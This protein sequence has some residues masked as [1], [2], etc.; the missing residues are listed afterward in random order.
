MNSATPG[1][2]RRTA[3]W[4]AVGLVLLA[5]NLRAAISGVAPLLDELQHR[6]N[7]PSTAMGALTTL[8]VLCLGVFAAVAP[9]LARRLGTETTLVGALALIAGGIAMRTLPGPDGLA[10]LLLFAGTV[11]AGAGI[12][13]SNVLM[14][15]V[16]KNVFP[17]RVGLFT[18]LT[19]MLM[20]TG[21][22]LASGLAVPLEERGGWRFSLAVWAFPALL[23]VLVWI[24]LAL[25]ARSAPRSGASSEHGAGRAERTGGSPLR[26]RLAWSVTLFLGMQS[27]VFYVLMSWLPA[28]MR[29]HGYSAATAGLMLSTVMLLGIPAGL[30]MPVLAARRADQRPLVAVVMALLIGGVLGLLTTPQAGWVWTIVLGVA[31]GCAFPL[32]FTLITLRSATPLWAAR[33][34]GMA[35]TAG[36]LLAA[37]GPFLI[38]ALHEASGSW[39]A[40]LLVLLIWLVPETFF[41][42]HAARPGAVGSA[43]RMSAEEV[44]APA[45]RRAADPRRAAAAPPAR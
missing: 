31:T 15:Y 41:A 10:A 13:L 12:A 11:L 29:D 9:V 22:A 25:R 21:A 19:M 35:Q 36:Y 3:V 34:S 5:F 16:I 6:L 42:W 8:P 43:E 30:V 1:I 4:T 18:G 17:A 33:L 24:P 20:S 7:L 45:A 40:P 23:G 26:S 32:A 37:A 44:G 14:P 2:T 38:G 28:I 27:L 39:S